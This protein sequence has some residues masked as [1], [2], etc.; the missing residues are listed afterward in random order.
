MNKNH[1]EQRTEELFRG[2]LHCAEAVFQAVLEAESGET[3]R[4]SISPRVATAF[5]G[6]IGRSKLGMGGAL[7]GGLMALGILRGRDSGREPWDE[8][9]ELADGLFRRFKGEYGC[10]RC[11]AVL[12][13]LGPQDRM[14]KC[15]RLAGRTAGM[16][17]EALSGAQDGETAARPAQACGCGC[18]ELHAPAASV[19]APSA[20]PA[21]RSA[22][23]CK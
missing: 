9:A 5:G 14:D 10:T 22:C 7:S 4:G 12:E 21:P 3:G 11:P 2:G 16:V 15:I 13:N 1:V 8:S 17:V 19:S 20:T 23:G 18:G 6:G